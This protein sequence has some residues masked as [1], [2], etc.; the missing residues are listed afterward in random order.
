MRTTAAA[1]PSLRLGE[2]E[3]LFRLP[4]WSARLFADQQGGRQASTLYDVSPDGTRFVVRQRNED[5]PAAT[6]L[7]NWQSLLRRSSGAGGG[8]AP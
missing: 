1:G 6:L 8:Q 5:S 7:V 4:R 2:P 3:T